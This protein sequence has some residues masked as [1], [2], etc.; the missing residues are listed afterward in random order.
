[1][2]AT[3][4]LSSIHA[5][6]PTLPVQRRYRSR[7]GSGQVQLAKPDARSTTES[8][9]PPTPLVPPLQDAGGRL[10]GRPPRRRNQPRG[11]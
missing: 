6:E 2:Q 5:P 4:C 1:V 3:P 11:D 9:T 10:P 7:P 8:A